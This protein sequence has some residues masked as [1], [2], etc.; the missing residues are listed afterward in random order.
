MSPSSKRTV[1]ELI[2]SG[3]LASLAVIALIDLRGLRKSPF[4]YLGSADMPRWLAWITIVLSVAI[5]LK[6]AAG[7][8]R[9]APAGEAPASLGEDAGGSAP[10]AGG[11]RQILQV[12]AIALATLA[13][14]ATI[15]WSLLPYSVATA[16]FLIAG[17]SV[18][19]PAG[20]RRWGITII[21]AVGVGVAGEYLFAR[22]LAMPFPRF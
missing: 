10:Q 17:I 11:R 7:L 9:P 8:L 3:F 18:L 6:A 2:F 22:V 4:D 12:S 1:G 14:I 5:A 21:L 20:R 16:L 13:Y 19:A 15:V